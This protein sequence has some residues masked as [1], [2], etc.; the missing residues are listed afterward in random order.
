MMFGGIPKDV[1]QARKAFEVFVRTDLPKHKMPPRLVSEA[2]EKN[3]EWDI[4]FDSIRGPVDS[5]IF[6]GTER[7]QADNLIVSSAA[8]ILAFE[9]LSKAKTN[10]RK[11]FQIPLESHHIWVPIA[12]S[13]A[14]LAAGYYITTRR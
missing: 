3:R 6:T 10:A 7:A 12:A 5:L 4:Y 1:L 8:M 2:L 13:L 9:K 14:G 11:I